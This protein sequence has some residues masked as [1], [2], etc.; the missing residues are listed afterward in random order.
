MHPSWARL[1]RDQCAAAGVP[2]FFKQW[3]EWRIKSEV[4]PTA[5]NLHDYEQRML[6]EGTSGPFVRVGKKAAGRLLDGLQHDEV[7][8]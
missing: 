4:D 5:L 3:G 8:A 7:P 2:F 6:D 1:L